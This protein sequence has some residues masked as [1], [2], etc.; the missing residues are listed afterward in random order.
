MVAYF[1]P[2]RMGGVG[3]VVAHLHAALLAAGHDSRVLTRGRARGDPR[4]ERIA[5]SPLGFVLRLAGC[6]AR[7]READVVHSHHGDA[8]LLLLA[9]RLRRVRTP[10]LVTFHVGHRGM[11][12]AER[13]Y[14]L[15]GRRFGTGAS[16][17][18]YRTLL[19][20]HSGPAARA[21]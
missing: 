19:A 21:R 18:L 8:V 11:G 9:L 6:A 3:E 2:E 1:P 20:G 17:W 10:V 14:A 12:E 4:V 16:G 7:A 5:A 13:P 15:C